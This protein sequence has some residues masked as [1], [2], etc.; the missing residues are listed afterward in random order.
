MDARV[1]FTSKSGF[2]NLKLY[3]TYAHGDEGPEVWYRESLPGLIAL[4]KKWDPQEKFG[5]MNPVP[6][7]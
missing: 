1:A 7:K 4:K 3:V 5:Y 2:P 6:A